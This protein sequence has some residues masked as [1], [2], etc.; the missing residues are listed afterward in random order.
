M[1]IVGLKRS[2]AV[3][4]VMSLVLVAG[5][6]GL[7][8]WNEFESVPPSRS[9]SFDGG[10]AEKE[11]AD[12]TAPPFTVEPGEQPLTLADC[13]TIALE[14]NPQIADSWQA[15]R[16]A[17]ARAGRAKADY[18]PTL[19][20]TSRAARE[21]PA[22][23]DNKVDLGTQNRYD[24]MFGVRWL[25]FD[26]GG[27]EARVDAAAAEVLAA[28]F[29]HNAA[30]QDVA[31]TVVEAYHNLLASQS[32]R[33][34]AVETLR[35]RDY[36]LRLAEARHLAGVVAKS[37]V[38]KAET[39]KADADLNLVRA[40]N[41]VHIARG[42]LA[43]AMGLPVATDFQVADAPEADYTREF[44]DIEALLAEAARSRP[45]LATALADVRSELAALRIARSRYSPAIAVDTGLGWIGRSFPPDQDQ[46]SVGLALDLPLF[47]GFD[48]TYQQSVST[49]DLARAVAR[50]ESML[51]GVELEVWT[52]YWQTIEAG[53]AIEA[54]RRFVASAEESARV[55]EGEY[56][57]GTGTIIAMIDA[58]TARTGARNRLIQARLDWRT[59]M[60]R[61][62]RAV[63]RS[64]AEGPKPLA[65]ESEEP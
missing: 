8:P 61:F 7:D 47:T 4:C 6:A 58:Q 39:Q 33:D 64:L 38:L 2:P 46:W 11:T 60:A 9:Q 54:A 56:K 35:Q 28:G 50:R 48:R 3:F 15:I 55:A 52:A 12:E 20:L 32:F 13:I 44:A 29:R 41:A 57:N 1:G 37:D 30:L 23:L 26:G 40:K 14:R 65:D 43:G 51:R 25:L 36:Q 16:A 24:A 45:E 34:L 63:G 42:R 31:L 19:T 53:E 59:A 5:C 27:R 21:N 49:A 10:T 17:A 22:E 62:E 18:L